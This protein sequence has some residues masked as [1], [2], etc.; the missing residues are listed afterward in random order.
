MGGEQECVPATGEC[1]EGRHETGSERVARDL[2]G[3]HEHPE[4]RRP[5]SSRPPRG[6]GERT[7]AHRQTPLLV[8][9]LAVVVLDGC[10]PSRQHRRAHI[11]APLLVTPLAVVALGQSAM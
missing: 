1:H 5:G 6:E 4:L 11:R 3:D 7:S 10:D 2:G 9:P 8:T